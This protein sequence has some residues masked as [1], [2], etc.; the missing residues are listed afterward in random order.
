[1]RQHDRRGVGGDR[2]DGS[3]VQR[4]TSGSG[5]GKRTLVEQAY[6][7]GGS[8]PVQRQAAS[9]PER[10]G[11]G[12]GAAGRVHAAAE[13][14]LEGGGGALPHLDT[15]QRAFGRHDVTGVSSH[16]GGPAEEACQA[17]G[18]QAYATGSSVAFAGAPD[19]H[20]AAHEAA[21]VVQQRGGVQLKGG[22][23]EAND[24][25][26]R[27]ADA[28]ADLVVQGKSAEATL[29]S[30]A[31][32]G[33]GT[34][35]A[36]QRFGSREHQSLGDNATGGASYDLGGHTAAIDAS[37][38]NRA[39][40][41]TH[42]DIVMLSGD[43]F[44]P[45]DTR[46]TASGGTEP[47]PDS[48]FVLAGIAST[49]PGQNVGTWDEVVYAIQKAIP[50]DPRF[51]RASTPE[52]PDGHPWARVTF[53]A[54]VMAA[55]DARY[56]RRAAANDEHFVAP[57]GTD[58]G[59]GAGDGV[60]AGGSYRAL[61]E[62]AIQLAYNQGSAAAGNAREAAAQHF[63]TDHFAAG[64][65]RTPRGSIRTHWRAIYP[66]FWTNIR[67]KIALDV[68][69]WINDHDAIGNVA[70][71]DQIYTTIQ[72]TVATE[73]ASI[74]PMGFDDLV[75]LV[76]HDFDNENGVA[77]VND[78][79][80]TW[81]LF[82]DGNLD[83]PDPENR[84]RAIAQQAVAL[85]IADVETAAQM[86]AR[87]GPT[88]MTSAQLFDS[89]RSATGG[90]AHP[91]GTKYGP[92]QL[93]P[94]PDDR[95]AAENGVQN[96]QRPNI[97][98]LW[99]APVRSGAAATFGSE[100]TASMQS[101][102]LNHELSGLASKFPPA[103]DTQLVF[104][105]HPRQG[106]QDGFLAPL[107]ANPHQGLLDII[108]FSPSRG[109]AGFNEDDAV[110]RE[111]NGEEGGASAA[112][113]AELRGLTLE[114]RSERIRVLISGYCGEDEGA[115]VVRL[116]E[117]APAGSRRTLYEMIEGHA[118]EGQFRDGVFTIDDNL[119]DALTYPQLDQ[120]KTLIGN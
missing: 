29:D 108:N 101:G 35:T 11:R 95:R 106:F 63:L 110:M 55:V 14:G 32:A 22:V 45:R 38:Y 48:L 114:Q 97:D 116:F 13:R 99:A 82:G 23:G 53:S 8:A 81:K 31:S 50:T 91:D 112:S 107:I 59:P 117:T 83:N 17:M 115:V 74:P 68:A 79:G 70:T 4:Q 118:W 103:Q 93:L 16:V 5:P 3:F 34:R 37:A 62:V 90:R 98:E 43:F 21:H 2:P 41:L 42:G 54:A 77:V 71:V 51:Q 61:H 113:E 80:D 52:H 85:G 75:S 100:I 19:L 92:E 94:R 26:E 47:D 46:P 7:Q 12:E 72:T 120:V 1:M 109:Q 105:V 30:M 36:V 88:P 27:H 24:Q 40:R 119:V 20:T 60:S 25:Y 76:T 18:A 6:E 33:G 64:H 104:T 96:W 15:I 78:V 39:F 10:S 57:A 87:K 66:N 86:G 89:V 65:L 44:S 84:T 111:V 69:T 49:N 73:T 56:L 28:A 9:G 102:E 67:N 58:R